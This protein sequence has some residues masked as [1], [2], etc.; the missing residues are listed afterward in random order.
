MQVK[1]PVRVALPA[2]PLRDYVSHYWL[3]LSNGDNTYSVL[4]DGAVDVVVA[5]GTTTCR[6]DIFG[7]TTSRTELPLD[8]GAHYLGIR[9]KPGQSR[10]FLDIKALELTNSNL[11][12]QGLLCTDILGVAETVTAD[13]MFEHLDAVL[14]KHLKHRPPLHSRIDDVLQCLEAARGIVS[15]P[16]LANMYGRSRRQFERHFRDVVGLPPKLF[17][18]V[19]RFQRASMLLTHSRL[20]LA[21]IAMELGYADQSHFTH[22]FVRFYGHPPSQARENVAFLQ[23]V[24]Y[25]TDNNESPI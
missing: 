6:V 17:S 23:D 1:V 3:S 19:I 2:A 22:E 8:V 21:Q 25:F 4:P 9:F 20:P 24:G 15:V 12:A 18:Q 14:L 16:Q 7:T 5:I 13:R 10:R 11:P